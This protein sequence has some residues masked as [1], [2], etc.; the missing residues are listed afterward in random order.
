MNKIILLLLATFS[1]STAFSQN[2]FKAYLKDAETKEHLI[3]ATAFVFGTTNG[4]TANEDGLVV[5]NNL[6][7]GKQILVFRYIGYKEKQTRCISLVGS[8]HPNNLFAKRSG[9]IR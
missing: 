8:T 4:S 7:D 2:T 9:R 5:V 6:A 1:I 3:G